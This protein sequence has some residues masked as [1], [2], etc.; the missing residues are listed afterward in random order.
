MRL[1]RTPQLKRKCSLFDACM[2]GPPIAYYYTIPMH[3]P[4]IAPPG[5]ECLTPDF[6]LTAFAAAHIPKRTGTRL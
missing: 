6:T 4:L 2:S 3:L 5:S 1:R